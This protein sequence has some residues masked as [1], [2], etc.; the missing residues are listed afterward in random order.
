MLFSFVG[1]LCGLDIVEVNPNLGTAE[2]VNK[3]V[4]AAHQIILGFLG[5]ERGGNIP[6]GITDIPLP[7]ALGEELELREKSKN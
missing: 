4:L 7:Q 3:T 6:V 2:D 5:C 1:T